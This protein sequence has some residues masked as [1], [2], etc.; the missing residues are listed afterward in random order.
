V[1]HHLAVHGNRPAKAVID[2]DRAIRPQSLN[3]MA[4]VYLRNGLL[5]LASAGGQRIPEASFMLPLIGIY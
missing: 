5:K 3:S 4:R 2:I 1:A